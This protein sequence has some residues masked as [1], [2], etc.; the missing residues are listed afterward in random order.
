MLQQLPVLDDI[1]GQV[2]I[3]YHLFGSGSPVITILSYIHGDEDTGVLV[4]E[5]IHEQLKHLPPG[6]GT[7]RYIL[8]S[9]PLAARQFDRVGYDGIDMNRNFPGLST[10]NATRRIANKLFNFIKK[11]D[12]VIDLHLWKRLQTPVIGISQIDTSE[13]G[14]KNREYMNI[15][16]PNAVWQIN[17]DVEWQSQYKSTT[18]YQLYQNKTAAILIETSYTYGDIFSEISH[19]AEGILRIMHQLGYEN[20]N[21]TPTKNEP[22][23][24]EA[25]M[26]TANMAGVWRPHVEVL[27]SVKEGEIIGTIF[28]PR[29]LESK[30]ILSP[31]SGSILQLAWPQVVKE[32]DEIYNLGI[33]DEQ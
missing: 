21:N 10:S 22:K 16:A 24:Y 28:D 19:C 13:I 6:K 32:G 3:P 23:Y 8:A 29:T 30:N 26:T 4:F 17:A 25:N 20:I 33:V 14:R 2:N 18:F 27:H 5:R 9:N 7:V 15:F 11:S 31:G 1:V 12:L